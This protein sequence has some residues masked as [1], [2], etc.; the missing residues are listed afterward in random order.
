VSDEILDPQPKVEERLAAELTPLHEALANATDAKKRKRI[1]RA[2]RRREQ[3]VRREVRRDVLSSPYMWR[4][5]P[6][7]HTQGGPP[8]HTP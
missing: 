3:R 1:E 2:I 8:W 4:I 7:R 5:G 6:V